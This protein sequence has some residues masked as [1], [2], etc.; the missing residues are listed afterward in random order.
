MN[1]TVNQ[2]IPLPTKRILASLALATMLGMHAAAIRA[3][4][5]A[6][7]TSAVEVGAVHNT[8]ASEGLAPLN[9]P[10]GGRVYSI[11]LQEIGSQ[12][13]M[14]LRGVEGSDSVPFDIRAD[15]VVTKARLVLDYSYSPS[16]IP[17]ISQL[18]VLVNDEVA[19]SLAL[20]KE[21][22]GTPQRRVVD[23]PTR[24]ITEFNV[25]K[26]QLIG[27]YTMEC[28]DPLHSSLWAKISNRSTLEIAVAPLPMTNDLSH[29]P[30][31]FFD[32]R[33]SRPLELPFVFAGKPDNATL[34]AAGA[35][36]SWFGVLASYRGAKFPSSFDQ[37]PAK[38]N[39][40]V[41]LK[42][43][44]TLAG[45]EP[46]NVEGPTVSVAPNPNDPNGKLLVIRGRDSNE[47]KLA[48][49][50]LSS[51][52]QTFSGESVLVNELT[53]LQP[54]EP[55]DAPK[56]LRSDRPV[57]LG[58]LAEEKVLNV[59]G[60]SP[61]PIPIVINLPPDL[62]GW[63][64]KG[65]AL[66]LKYRYTPQPHST[67][68]SLII[69]TSEQFIKSMPLLSIERLGSGESL[70]SKLQK[71]DSLPLETNLRVPLA[72]L[73][74]H[75]EL[76]FRFMYDYIK[77]GECRDIIIDNMR[78]AIDPESTV[79]ISGY[80]HFIAMP[81]LSAFNNNGFPFTRL[82][83]LSE[84]AVILPDEAGTTDI[85][86]YLAVLGRLG[87]ASGYPATAVTV[88]QAGMIDNVANK[89]LL[90]L[91][92]GANQPL[93]KEW[94]QYMP[95]SLDGGSQRF[96]LSDLVHRV[97]SW[98]SPSQDENLRKA[99]NG[100]SL[101]GEGANAVFAGFESPL[102]SGRS[103]VLI[104]ASKAA[105]LD[106]AINA[107]IG[108]KSYKQSIQGSLSLIRGKQI[109]PLVADQTYYVGSLGPFEFV[110][111]FLAHHVFVF[112]LVAIL[113]TLL[114]ASLLY[115]LLHAI[116]RRRLER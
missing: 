37:L 69:G 116:A 90:V 71:D 27:H 80:S 105:G 25:L 40:V 53:T 112:L 31:P 56:W 12:Y 1:P 23:I 109:T 38:G 79:D 102:A 113:G 97:R 76:N 84:T 96:E 86:T 22:A 50:A 73:P 32:R 48:A 49:K 89:D 66:N 18:N 52:S 72:A 85:S 65:I 82:A 54:R 101:T 16:L 6:V 63:H 20:P 91:G 95:A 115:V 11:S 9:A 87:Q 111:W 39:A 46:S 94:A 28:E 107:M 7:D 78:G 93:I 60:Y 98:I 99:R 51:G 17:D 5:P 83:D 103:V 26:L 110:W 61:A 59:S 70:L 29:L 81:D 100:L 30:L 10:D 15:E 42:S 62:F 64:D 75:S 57:K 4:E 21:Q 44:S 33:D 24:F 108:G 34:E 19:T 35:L 47:L 88:T 58:E 104:S 74:A 8:T 43:G 3:E 14:T 41:L 77:Q 68:S 67:N 13:P 106:D 2:S 114:I 45:L 92:S 36:S 55:Y